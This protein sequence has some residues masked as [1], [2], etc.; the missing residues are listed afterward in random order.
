MAVAEISN[1][2]IERGVDFNV[3]FDLFNDDS[4]GVSL[5]GISTVSATI[6]KHPSSIISEDFTCTVVT[7]FPAVLKLELTAQQTLNLESGRNYFDVLIYT[8]VGGPRQKYIKGTAIVL[9]TMTS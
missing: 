7:T 1:I 6:R 8:T 5:V 3:E 4:S 9:D 2:T